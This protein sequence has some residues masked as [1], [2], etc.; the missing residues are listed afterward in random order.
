MLKHIKTFGQ[1]LAE[2]MNAVPVDFEVDDYNFE[3]NSITVLCY[4]PHET[5]VETYDEVVID[6]DDFESWVEENIGLDWTH[7]Y[8]DPSDFYGHGQDSGTL[9]V[10]EWW[11]QADAKEIYG[12]LKNYIK[13]KGI[14][15]RPK[16][17]HHMDDI[18]N[19]SDYY[20]VKDWDDRGDSYVS[21]GGRETVKSYLKNDNPKINDGDLVVP[22]GHTPR[23]GHSEIG[24][25]INVFFNRN[26]EEALYGIRFFDSEGRTSLGKMSEDQIEKWNG[27]IPEWV[28]NHPKYNA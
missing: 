16:F 22:I 18:T 21:L 9:T 6:R 25:V 20:N 10:E 11:E 26:T 23:K 19:E 8:H 14:E 2:S 7:D 5:D 17:D 24:Q 28:I 15:V 4:F 13:D 1:Y 27:E 3:D 12:A